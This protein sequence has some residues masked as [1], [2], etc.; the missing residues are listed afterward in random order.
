MQNTGTTTV[1]KYLEDIFC[2]TQ[3]DLESESIV[4][5]IN[6]WADEPDIKMLAYK[7]CVVVCSSPEKYQQVRELLQEKNRDEIFEFPLVYGQT[8]HYIP[9]SDSINVPELSDKYSYELLCGEEINKL[10]DIK[11]FDNSLVF[12]EEGNTSAKIVF[13]AKKEDTVVGI[14]GAGAVTDK[15]WEVGIDV[16]AGFRDGGLGTMLTKKLTLEILKRGILP[17]YSASV[18]NLGS[19]MVAARAGYIPC[20]VDTFGSVFDENYAYDY[21]DIRKV[22]FME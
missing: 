5:T 22:V 18:T 12:D 2:C 7:K 19:Q 15:M 21:D 16:K 8:I 4:F 9:D 13:T 11:G 3:N 20:W 10:A 1:Q 6:S 17:F 14:A